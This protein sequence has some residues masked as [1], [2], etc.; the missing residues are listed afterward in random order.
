[1]WLQL[2]AAQGPAECCLAVAKAAKELAREAQSLGVQ[3]QL[4]ECIDGPEPGTWRSLL[5]WLEGDAR[6]VLADRWNGSIQWTFA[7]PY[8]PAHK[9]K[10]WFIGGKAFPASVSEPSSSNQSSS[11]QT[12][13]IHYQSCKASG[14]GGQHVN[15]TDS[16]VRATH[17]ATG[18]SVK[19]QTERSQHANKRL[20]KALLL[21]KLEQ[22]RLEQE[23]DD[24]ASRRLH[25]HQVERGRPVRCFKE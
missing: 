19:V 1:M 17:V 10:N 15:T 22:Q 11:R 25:H 24:K 14:A 18:L 12:D 3:A 23:A 13:A 9:R 20:A 8:R 16:A 2:S 6:Q 4:V 21:H 7:S 5:Y